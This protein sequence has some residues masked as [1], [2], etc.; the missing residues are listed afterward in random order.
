MKNI[1]IY[2]P[3]SGNGKVKKYLPLILSTINNKYGEVDCLETTHA[4]HAH[5]Y[6]KEHAHEFDYV[7]VA[8]GDG[9]LNETVSGIMES[10]S[11]PIIGYLPTGTCNDVAHSLGISKNIKKA[12]KNLASG[13]PTYH[14]VFSV[15]NRFGIYVCCAGL[16]TKSS[17]TTKRKE[18][19]S[20]GKIAYFFN[21]IKELFSAKPIKLELETNEGKISTSVALLLILN[22]KS[23]AGFKLNKDADLDNGKVDVL[24][25]HSHEKHIL[26]SEILRITHTFLFGINRAKKNKHVT[27]L[28][29]S[30][31]TIKTDSSI[32][33]NLDG[34]HGIK[35]SFE[36]KVYQKQIKIIAPN[37]N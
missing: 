19:K 31:F 12:I 17:Y 5:E 36:F 21:G 20:L 32:A 29:L 2:N 8:G 13:T 34:E 22:S 27:Y 33:I 28:S 24:L 23:V 6:L 3:E 7:F 15:N 1:F 18:K 35:G 14:D 25:F 30:S 9:T 4:G 26:L 37:K 10:A 11:R 16:F